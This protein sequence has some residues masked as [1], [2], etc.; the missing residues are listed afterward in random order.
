VLHI[1]LARVPQFQFYFVSNRLISKRPFRGS[2]NV[3]LP[4]GRLVTFLG[5]NVNVRK[6]LLRV[7]ITSPRN[8]ALL[9]VVNKVRTYTPS[10][11]RMLGDF[12]VEF[13]SHQLIRHRIIIECVFIMKSYFVFAH[14]YAVCEKI[15]DVIS[16]VHINVLIELSGSRPKASTAA[17][18]NRGV[19]FDNV[20]FGCRANCSR[21]ISETRSR[22]RQ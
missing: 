21:Y 10:S 17:L 19:N 7:L 12:V 4:N 18:G 5:G 15:I 11:V 9:Y 20:R 6:G 3:G 13:A 2:N 14:Y 8:R 1:F 16:R 22:R